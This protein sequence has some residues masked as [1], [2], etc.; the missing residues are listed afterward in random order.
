[1]IIIYLFFLRESL[2]GFERVII[3]S[4]SQDS[5]IKIDISTMTTLISS[6]LSIDS[7]I[8]DGN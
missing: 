7:E 6:F 3:Y 4:D 8:P 2:I 5:Y 1:M